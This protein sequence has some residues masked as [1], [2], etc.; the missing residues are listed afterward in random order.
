MIVICFLIV[1][2]LLLR[3]VAEGVVLLEGEVLELVQVDDLAR[4]EDLFVAA[5]R[6][7][8]QVSRKLEKLSPLSPLPPATG[9]GSGEPCRLSR[10][11]PGLCPDTL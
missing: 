1:V 9:A 5:L 3:D 4:A 2:M 7:V 11:V 6:E 8:S 10:G